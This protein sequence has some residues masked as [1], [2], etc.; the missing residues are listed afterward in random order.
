MN[1]LH[2]KYALEVARLGSL[3]K[4]A[5]T[6]LIA[7]PNISRSIKELEASLGITIFSRSAKGME[8]TPDGEEFISYA[9]SILRQIDD[10][11]SRYKSGT[12]KRPRFSVCAPHAY[13][14]AKAFAVFAADSEAK[15][16]ELCYREMLTH[17]AVEAVAD[18]DFNLGIVRCCSTS[19]TAFKQAL[20]DKS[21]TYELVGEFSYVLLMNKFNPLA[22]LQTISYEALSEYTEVSYSDNTL[23]T[24]A[25]PRA[26]SDGLS[27]KTDGKIFIGSRAEAYE[28]LE[29]VKHAFMWVSPVDG[30]LCSKYGLT[31]RRLEGNTKTF[32]DM[33]I[34]RQNYK[35]TALDNMFITALC[36]ARRQCF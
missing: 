12:P 28:T 20:E 24:L 26:F 36:E 31:V 4:A 32:K 6:L 21:L 17:K 19:N 3:N 2:M 34:R 25:D 22:K 14:T 18:H 5:E 16:S 9:K 30:Q 8:L 7:Q 11:A 29:A 13:Y 33:V 35:L 1:I 23:N 15:A 10:V 27:Y